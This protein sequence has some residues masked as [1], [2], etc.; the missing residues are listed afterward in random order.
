MRLSLFSNINFI[1]DIY[2]DQ[3]FAGICGFTSNKIMYY[4]SKFF[5]L[6]ISLLKEL[7][8]LKRCA[9]QNDLLEKMIEWH[10]GYTW[11]CKSQVL[12]PLSVINF[13]KYSIIYNYWYNS[14][15]SLLSSRIAQ[16]EAD[17]RELSCRSL[18]FNDFFPVTDRNT[19][20]Y[21]ELLLQT[22]VMTINSIAD[23]GTGEVSPPQ[24]FQQRNQG[25]GTVGAFVRSDRSARC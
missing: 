17:Y 3:R 5:T 1:I 24:D 8:Q 18:Y 11:Y 15:S 2:F 6:A 12:N 4:F 19:I 22:G 21:A 13:F 20:N 23:T 10:N 14:G 7:G 9:T 25:L 16:H